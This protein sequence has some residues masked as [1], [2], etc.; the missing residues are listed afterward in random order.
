MVSVV[1][2]KPPR[3]RRRQASEARRLAILEAGLDIFISEGFAAARLDD[4]ATRAGVAKGTIYLFFADKQELFEQVVLGALGPVLAS[5]SNV[6]DHSDAP[7]ATVLARLFEVCQHEMLSTRRRE[8]PRLVLTEAPRFPKIAEFYHRE[9]VSKG[10]ELVRRISQRAHE[11]GELASDALVRFP[12]L[13]FGPVLV[14]IL[15]EGM[16]ARFEPLDVAGL[17]NAHRELLLAPGPA[18]GSSP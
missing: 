12:H 16:F 17:L 8:I 6:A 18:R 9:V 7:F 13:L 2:C 11:R 1:T 14:G 15:W 3:D 10:L 4:I 5:L